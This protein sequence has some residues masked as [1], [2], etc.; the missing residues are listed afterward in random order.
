MNPNI[1]QFLSLLLILSPAMLLPRVYGQAPKTAAPQARMT[2]SQ[3]KAELEKSTNPVL[4]TK[5]V[6]KKKFKID[7][8]AVTR[9]TLFSSLADSIAYTGKPGKVYGPYGKPGGQFLVQVLSKAPNLFYRISQIFIDTSVFRY[10]VADSIGK[11]IIEKLANGS[12]SFGQLAQ[13]YSMGGEGPY[14]GDLGWVARGMLLPQIENE[15]SKRKKGEVFRIWSRNGLH[16]IKKTEDP[17]QDTGF[18]L[19]MRVFL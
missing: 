15:L 9:T 13:T 2:V 3:L 4:Y 1:R 6:L 11:K 5:Q 16:I 10:R 12:A 8:I 14:K 19:I 18:A 7:T 17:R